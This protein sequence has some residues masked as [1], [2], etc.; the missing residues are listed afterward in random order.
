MLKQRFVLG[1][2]IAVLLLFFVG[3]N[4]NIT[5]EKPTIT[6]V[7][8]KVEKSYEVTTQK[9]TAPP[10]PPKCPT[11]VS[12]ITTSETLDLKSVTPYATIRQ[13]MEQL[14]QPKPYRTMKELL[15][16][17]STFRVGSPD[18]GVTAVVSMYK[19]KG[20]VERWL[21][22]LVEQTH[23]PKEIWFVFFAS[24]L[25]EDLRA[26]ILAA[27]KAYLDKGGQIPILL[28]QGEVQ[29]K[30]W[31][32]FQLA[33]QVHNP[34]VVVCDD[35]SIPSKKYF[36]SVL[37]VMH[38]E[39]YGRGIF[40]TKGTSWRNGDIYYGPMSENPVHKERIYEVDV[41][42]GSWFMKNEWVK[43]MFREKIHSWL[44]A[45]DFT[46][47][48]AARKYADLRCFVMPIPPTEPERWGFSED[49]VKISFSGD[50][51]GHVPGTNEARGMVVSK[52]FERG[53]RRMDTLQTFTK[54]GIMAFA[55]L[56]T[57]HLFLHELL[58]TALTEND[59]MLHF[60]TSGTGDVVPPPAHKWRTFFNHAIGRDYLVA[61]KNVSMI[62][63]TPYFFDM[64]LQGSISTA[65]IIIGSNPT[66]AT[67]SAVLTAQLRG[68]V[69][70]NI[71]IYKQSSKDAL[72]RSNAIASLA[73]VTFN[74]ASDQ[75]P[76]LRE[77][78]EYKKLQ[79]VLRHVVQK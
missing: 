77:T 44:S 19:R 34:Y 16:L 61:A 37:H 42:G 3:Y 79:E 51:T 60:A 38:T 28:V 1:A 64:A 56:N 72:Q 9:C 14:A 35:D 76:T 13:Q 23:P 32:R 78:Q 49:Y 17:P 66:P 46:L 73:T 69:I 68:L 67:V 11:V 39:D 53:E 40:G 26:E 70:V 22:T 12:P 75:F 36:E 8:T 52:Q 57:D 45:E 5:H 15:D 24:P 33:M 31:G 21:N 18:F 59:A 50:T 63:D 55:D 58:T 62:G 47:C 20:H 48:S 7:H 27:R 71:N 65:L 4:L 54:P 10:T 41:V 2:A 30:Y 43:L 74:F 6:P 29:Y 25:A